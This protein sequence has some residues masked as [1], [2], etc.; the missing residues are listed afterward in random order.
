V[1]AAG[2][3]TPPQRL[4]WYW[5]LS[6]TVDP[7][8]AVAAYDIDGFDASAALVGT[9]HAHGKRVICYIS[10]GTYEPWRPDAAALAPHA[11]RGV[12]GWPSEKWLDVRHPAVRDA[13]AARI[14]MCAGKGFDAVEPDNVDGYAN[15]S[16]FQL[17]AADQLTYNRFLADTA[18]GAGLAAFLKN[19]TDQAAALEPSF[20]GVVSEE[21]NAYDECDAF[22]AFLRH[23]KPVLNAEYGASQAFCAADTAAG[24]MGARFD[25]DPAGRTFSPCW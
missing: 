4:T 13:I 19:D 15:S 25:L 9:L 1:P 5:Q 12:A 11:G 20:D 7:S 17:T 10:A 23:G 8:R 18:H 16:G 3:W 6:G 2:R 22:A 24:I 21:C 14:R